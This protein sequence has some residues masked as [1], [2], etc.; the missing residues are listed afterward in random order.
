MREHDAAAEARL[1]DRFDCCLPYGD[2]HAASGLIGEGIEISVNGAFGV[3]EEICNPPPSEDV[4]SSRRLD[5]L[6][7]WCEVKGLDFHPL[8][9]PISRVAASMIRGLH[10]SAEECLGLIVTISQYPAQRAALNIVASALAPDDAEGQDRVGDLES[11]IRGRWD[12]M[13]V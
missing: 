7:E 8:A 12:G 3:L 10:A 9:R 11:E 5:L 1:F 13:G 2:K 4:S 6:N